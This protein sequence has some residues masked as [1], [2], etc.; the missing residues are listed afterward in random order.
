M[1]GALVLTQRGEHALVAA[2]AGRA[3][4]PIRTCFLNPLHGRAD[5]E[6]QVEWQGRTLDV[7]MCTACRTALQKKKVPDILD[8][9]RRG[10]PRHYFETGVEPWSSSGYGSL[11]PDLLKLLSR[12]GT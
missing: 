4:E 2:R 9:V 5:R 8:V 12:R 10:E 6:R 11:E 7:P 3:W 1:V